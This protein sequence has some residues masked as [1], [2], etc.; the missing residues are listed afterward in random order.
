MTGGYVGVGFELCKILFAHNATVWVAGRSESKAQK[1]LS[2]IKEAFPKSSGNINF[3][4]LDLADLSTIKPAVNSF[5]SQEQRL[6]VLVNNAGVC[7]F[8]IPSVYIHLPPGQL[9]I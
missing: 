3:L 8:L 9:S 1:A 4:H 7:P 2:N 6:D 5:T